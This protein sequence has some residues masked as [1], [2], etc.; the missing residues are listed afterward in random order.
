MVSMG[1][2]VGVINNIEK[3]GLP[4]MSCNRQNLLTRGGTRISGKGVHMY[5]SVGARFADFISL[6]F[7]I[8]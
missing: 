1:L 8:P 4:V 2:F 7:N 3:W 6:F 5:N